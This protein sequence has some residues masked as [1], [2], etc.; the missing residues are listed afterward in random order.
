MDRRK[1]LAYL[2]G[3]SALSV[4][5]LSE[6]NAAIYQSIQNLNSQ[7]Q[8]IFS[9]DGAY[10]DAVSKHYLFQDGL[11]MMNNGT[12]GPM[13]EPVFNTMMK[14]FKLQ[15]TNPYDCYN[16]LPTQKDAIRTKLAKFINASPDEVAITRNTTEGMNVAASGVELKEGD[17]VIISTHEHP[18]GLHPWKMKA[19]RFLTPARMSNGG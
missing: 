19:K 14:Y 7:Y 12:L 2:A 5:A 9:P 3:G 15:C 11:I 4:T 16:F 18:G 10:W 6:L 13:P 8:D 1:F 17:E